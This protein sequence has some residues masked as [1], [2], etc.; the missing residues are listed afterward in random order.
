MVQTNWKASSKWE[1]RNISALEEIMET[2]SK[3]FSEKYGYNIFKGTKSV[4]QLISQAEIDVVGIS[5]DEFGK[6]IYAIDVAFHTAGLN[7][8]TRDETAARVLKKCIRTAMCIYGYFGVSDGTIIFA[9]PKINPA[10]VSDIERCMGDLNIVLSQAGLNFTTRIIGNEDFSEKVLEPI[11][12]TINEV[13]DTSELFM[14]SL[15]MY[16]LFVKTK[17][18]REKSVSKARHKPSIS[19]EMK[20]IE[21][22][23]IEGLEEMKIGTIVRT[24]VRNMLERGEVSREEVELMQT[25]EYSKETFDIQFA[26]LI[27]VEDMTDELWSRYYSTPVKIFGDEYYICSQWYEVPANNDRIYLMKWLNKKNNEIA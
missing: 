21:F 20:A 11:L 3:L 25:K 4:Q 15:Q 8:G 2:S 5:F 7:Y 13:A 12:G 27:K 18:N 23:D 9:S 10:E 19:G 1:L 6:H 26:L 14:R 24:V 22:N 17:P 16:N